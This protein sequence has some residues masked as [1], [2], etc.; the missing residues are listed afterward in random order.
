MERPDTGLLEEVLGL[1][2]PRRSPQKAAV[3]SAVL[4]GAGQVYNRRLDRAILT[5][6]WSALLFGVGFAMFFLG[7][8]GHWTRGLP[9]PAPLGDII[10]ANGWTFAGLWCLAWIGFWVWNI[11]DAADSARKITEG[12]VDIRHPLRWQLVHVLGSQLLGLLPF[13]GFLFPPGMVA[14]ALDAAHQRR[15]PDHKRLLREGG[16]A[17]LEWTAVRVALIS[18]AGLTLVW[19]VWWVLRAV[20]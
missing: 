10:A 6:L 15:A 7:L 13:V 1:E 3:L 5:W 4:V 20:F 12:L 2:R 17:L 8:L 19:V 18:A 9:A 16:Q 11:R 14:E